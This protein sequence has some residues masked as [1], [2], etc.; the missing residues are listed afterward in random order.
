MI[1]RWASQLEGTG[2]RRQIADGLTTI[3]V[4]AL[5][6]HYQGVITHWLDSV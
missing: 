4:P 1:E 3:R 2:M 6:L 5:L